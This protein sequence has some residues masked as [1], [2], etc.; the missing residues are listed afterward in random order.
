MA[1][2]HYVTPAPGGPHQDLLF[3]LARALHDACPP[4]L[5]VSLVRN[6][7]VGSEAHVEP[8]LLV[9]RRPPGLDERVWIDPREDPPVLVVEVVSP[10]PV[11]AENDLLAKRRLYQ[12]LGIPSYWLAGP[13]EPSLVALELQGGRYV[14]TIAA[15]GS[16]PSPSP[17]IGR[18][19][20]ASLCRASKRAC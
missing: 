14:E 13:S 10:G 11:N 3:A 6:L 1:G 4:E 9:L 15:R 20:C 16:Q 8:D 2:K 7:R 5:K 18:S 12:D 19:P 17:P